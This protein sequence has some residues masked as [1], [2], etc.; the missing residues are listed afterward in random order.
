MIGELLKKA[1]QWMDRAIRLDEDGNK[2]SMMLK[3][4]DKAVEFEAQGLAAGESWD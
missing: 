1:N 2:T 3:C 4:L